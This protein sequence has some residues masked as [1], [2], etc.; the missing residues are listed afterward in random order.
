M[1]D[2]AEV[3]KERVEA[4]ILERRLKRMERLIDALCMTNFLLEQDT[5]DEE[6]RARAIEDV[7]T[8]AKISNDKWN[9]SKKYNDLRWE[10]R[11]IDEQLNLIEQ[12]YPDLKR[13]RL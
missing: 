11:R 9:A 6:Y 5:V 7:N 8:N 3:P 12:D 4:D 1:S 10:L 13:N 2:T